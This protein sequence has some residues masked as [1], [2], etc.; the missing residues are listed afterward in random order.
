MIDIVSSYCS[1]VRSVTPLIL[2]FLGDNYRIVSHYHLRPCEIRVCITNT[3][4][5][6]HGKVNDILNIWLST[7]L[8]IKLFVF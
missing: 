2:T 4:D 7:G 8:Q 3:A 6:G 5:F 1:Y